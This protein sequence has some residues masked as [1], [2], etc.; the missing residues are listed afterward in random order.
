MLPKTSFYAAAAI[1][2]I[3]SLYAD[4]DVIQIPEGKI[5]SHTTVFGDITPSAGPRVI[6]GVGL[7]LTGDYLYWTAREDGLTYAVTGANLN[8]SSTSNT[9]ILPT[10]Q[11]QQYQPDFRYKSG[12]KLGIGFDFGHDKWDM[13]LDYTW[14]NPHNSNSSVSRIENQPMSNL[15]PV[16]Y[17]NPYNLLDYAKAFWNL[18][19][20]VIDW[21]LGRNFY[22]SKFL[23]LRPFFGLKGTW[24]KQKFHVLYNFNANPNIAI[25]NTSYFWGL[26]PM[27]GVNTAWH[28]R[29]FWSLFADLT[30]SSL[31]G[32]YYVGRKDTTTSSNTTYYNTHQS[33][34]KIRP[35]MEI[36]TGLR[37]EE[38]FY[39]NRFH[40]SLQV[41]WEQQ[42]WF[43]QNQFDFY[44]NART[45]DLTLQG[46]TAKARFDF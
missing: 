31:W 7:Y 32:A 42:V 1:S 24:Q 3:P 8:N 19:F 37:K 23:S 25:N 11:G 45:G 33:F 22:I 13:Y 14:F 34:H 17:T 5:T 20:N 26:G 27:A 4:S 9:N 18:N 39:N 43:N 28:F 38:W 35:V 12:F 46:L 40:F 10:S 30:L 15:I 21:N 41:G 44:Q 29:G 16:A 2:V 36:A 6:D